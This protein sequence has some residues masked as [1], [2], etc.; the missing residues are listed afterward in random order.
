MHANVDNVIEAYHFS[1]S[2]FYHMYLQIDGDTL[3]TNVNYNLLTPPANYTSMI[4]YEETGG[5]YDVI[6][7]GNLKYTKLD[8]INN[9]ATGVFSFVVS[10]GSISKTITEGKFTDMFIQ[11]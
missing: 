7:S 11:Q 5:Y 2:P 4:S 10:D 8:Y 9:K 6:I 3:L 1:P